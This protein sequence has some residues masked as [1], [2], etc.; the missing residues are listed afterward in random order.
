[1]YTENHEVIVKKTSGSFFIW[2]R[3]IQTS[4]KMFLFDWTRVRSS[5]TYMYVIKYFF[6]VVCPILLRLHSSQP[7]IPDRTVRHLCT[8]QTPSF[9]V[10]FS[11]PQRSA[12]GPRWTE[13]V[14][15]LD[16]V[17]LSQLYAEDHY[18]RPSASTQLCS[19]FSRCT[20][21]IKSLG[22]TRSLAQLNKTE[23]SWFLSQ[24]NRS[25]CLSQIR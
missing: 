8:Q 11:A 12:V 10:D 17:V 6:S 21:D 25:S 3:C 24:S 5:T 19:R 4:D 16:H 15:D 7:R 1:L 13:S 14:V 9:P 22:V 20:D 18:C 23:A 2:T